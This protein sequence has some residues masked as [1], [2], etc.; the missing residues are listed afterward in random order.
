MLEVSALSPVGSQ[1]WIPAPKAGPVPRPRLPGLRPGAEPSYAA[2]PTKAGLPREVIKWLQSLDLSFSYKHVNRNF[3]NGYLVAEIFSWYYPQNIDIGVFNN[4]VSFPSKLKNWS[5]L[6][7]FFFKKKLNIPKELID[8]TIH[9]KPGGA[10]C[11]IQHIYTLLTNRQAKFILDDEINFMDYNYQQKLPIVA[12]STVTNAIRNNLK[13]TEILERPDHY[14]NKQKALGIINM[15]VHQRQLARLEH[16]RRFNLKPTL[17]ELATR[18]PLPQYQYES[19]NSDSKRTATNPLIRSNF[20]PLVLKPSCWGA[21]DA[22][23]LLSP[24]Y[25]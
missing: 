9:S 22:S 8:A 7:S 25:Y 2:M 18:L 24:S 3:C 12:R 20:S 4:G 10:E 6:K 17:G 16:P 21:N 15:H 1:C 23:S 14:T 5:Q 13:L 19:I 11:L